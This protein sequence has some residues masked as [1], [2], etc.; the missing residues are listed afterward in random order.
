MPKLSDL[1]IGTE[2][3]EGVD[4]SEMPEQRSG[5]FADPPQPGTYRFRLPK[6]DGN[7]PIFDMIES[8]KDGKKR[9]NILFTDAFALTI[10]QSPGGT[11]D[12]E[13]YDFRISNMEFDR[14]RK[15]ETPIFAS[16]LDYLLRDGFKDTGRPKTNAAYGQ[17]LVKHAGQEFTADLEF[18][19]NCND[20]RDIYVDDG[21]GGSEKVEGTKGCGAKYYQGGK[22]G[23][24][25]ERENPEDPNSP[26]VYPVRIRCAGRDGVPCDAIIRAFSRLRNF[27]A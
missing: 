12:G 16:D 24:G 1:G 7:T 2:K 3:I 25:K 20:Q 9:L 15:G 18:T 21:S 27:R 13:G 23:I 11:H 4:F 6:F 10:V 8:K 26:L 19:W 5:T 22:N 17:A 14:A